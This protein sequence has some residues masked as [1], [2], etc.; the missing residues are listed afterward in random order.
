[1]ARRHHCP[2][3][4]NDEYIECGACPYRR[5]VFIEIDHE[6]KGHF[7]QKSLFSFDAERVPVCFIDINA[8]TGEIVNIRKVQKATAWKDVPTP[9]I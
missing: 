9:T 7:S 8:L 2:L 1:M 4:I 5:V 3:A 6:G